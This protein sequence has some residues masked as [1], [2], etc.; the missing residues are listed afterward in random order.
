[1]TSSIVLKY[2]I[3]PSHEHSEGSKKVYTILI[4]ILNQATKKLPFYNYRS[5]RIISS[6]LYFFLTPPL[7]LEGVPATK[8]I[9]CKFHFIMR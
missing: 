8:K 6:I 2:A 7:R 5:I 3:I 4:F 9:H 1:M